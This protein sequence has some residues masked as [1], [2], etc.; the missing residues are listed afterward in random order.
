MKLQKRLVKLRRIRLLF[1]LITLSFLCLGLV[2]VS[3]AEFKA[4]A[5]VTMTTYELGHYAYMV[6]GFVGEY[7]MKKHGVKL[8]L[9]P[10]GNDVGRMMALRSGTTH[11]IGQSLD[12]HYAMDGTTP[13]YARREWGPQDDLRMVWMGKL[14]GQAF[15]VRGTSDIKT[16][17]DLKGKRLNW[18]PGSVFVELIEAHLAYANLTWN[19]VKKVNMP[20]LAAS[21]KAIIDGSLDA[22]LWSVTSP[23]TKEIEAS[24]YGIRFLQEDDPEGFA[25]MRKKIS[26]FVP[27]K[28]TF[29]TSI[30]EDKP[31]HCVTYAYPMT[32]CRADLDDDVAYFMTKCIHEG[33]EH[34]ASLSPIIK[35]YWTLDGFIDLYEYYDYAILHP[36]TVRYLK[37]IGRWK[38][39]YDK[40]QTERA[41]RYKQLRAFFEKVGDEALDKGIKDKDFSEFWL[42]KRAEFLAK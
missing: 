4:P 30:T 21:G 24:P 10:I 12:V 11:F 16:I 25:R 34:M 26:D 3:A 37:E 8:R 38:P 1:T 42:K 7:M 31:L 2:H 23:G 20:G 39:E 19:D 33:Y 15:L 40:F 17:A 18:V 41:A 22:M 27:H 28:A 36:G 35:H 6:Y 13:R 9:I 5:T 14:S 32:I 29:G